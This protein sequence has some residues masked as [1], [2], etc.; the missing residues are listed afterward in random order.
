VIHAVYTKVDDGCDRVINRVWFKVDDVG[1]RVINRVWIKVDD[2]REEVGPRID[3]LARELRLLSLSQTPSTHTNV[4]LN[5]V[6]REL[7]RLQAEVEGL[8]FQLSVVS[9]DSAGSSD[10][11]GSSVA[12]PQAPQERSMAG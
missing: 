5:S 3:T 1:D 10:E 7:A 9:A 4:L 12:F 6:V 11:A 8:R 2:S